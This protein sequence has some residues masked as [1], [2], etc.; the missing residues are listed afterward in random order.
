[1]F[2]SDNTPKYRDALW[3]WDPLQLGDDREEIPDEYDDLADLIVEGLA[4][5][6]ERDAIAHDLTRVVISDWL[7]QRIRSAD[8]SAS[9]LH[10]EALSV[11][12]AVAAI[13]DDSEF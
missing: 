7:G 4:R 6:M 1:M 2:T 10:R 13:L 8:E 9:L 5:H 11:V 3:A 12:N